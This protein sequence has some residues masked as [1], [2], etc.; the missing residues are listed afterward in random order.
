MAMNIN[1]YRFLV[2]DSLHLH[3]IFDQLIHVSHDG[4]SLNVHQHKWRYSVA[5]GERKVFGVNLLITKDV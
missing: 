1:L 4:T 5:D 2:L 3:V